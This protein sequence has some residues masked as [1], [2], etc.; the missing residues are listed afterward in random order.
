[1]GDY[2]CS[3]V[4]LPAPLSGNISQ[5]SLSFVSPSLLSSNYQGALYVTVDDAAYAGLSWAG[6]VTALPTLGAG[7]GM[8]ITTQAAYYLNGGSQGLVHS[9][10]CN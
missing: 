1:M 7:M 6:V 8:S 2:R 4:Y 3:I 5:N 9:T 10:L